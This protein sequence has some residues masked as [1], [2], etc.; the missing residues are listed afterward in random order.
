MVGYELNSVLKCL[1]GKVWLTHPHR[2]PYD[3]GR[4]FGFI[5]WGSKRLI[6]PVKCILQ[7]FVKTFSLCLSYIL[8]VSPTAYLPG[9]MS[10]MHACYQSAQVRLTRSLVSSQPIGVGISQAQAIQQAC[11]VVS[12]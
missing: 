8:G 9:H 1:L 12:R 11:Q 4:P 10:S 2:H 6:K 7:V 5:G 3:A